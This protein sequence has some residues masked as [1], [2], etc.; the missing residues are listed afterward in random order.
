M[1]RRI[2]LVIGASG[3]V[4]RQVSTALAERGWEVVGTGNSRAGAGLLPLDLRD[5]TA[6]RETIARVRPTLCV[7]SAALTDVE[8][9]EAEPAL[10]EALNARAPAVTAAA[11]RAV[12]GRTIFLSTEY[13]FDGTAGPYAEDDPVCPISVYG[14][15]KLKGEQAVLAADPNSLAVRTTVV[16]SYAPEELNFAMQLINRLSNGQRMRI[17]GD[18][19]SSPTYAP[20]LAEAIARLCDSGFAVRG[21]LNIAGDEVLDRVAFARR[22]AAALNLDPGLI[23]AVRTKDL[24]QKAGRPLR[25]GL[26][27]DKLQALGV[28]PPT[29][30]AALAEVARLR[31][32]A[33]EGYASATTA[34]TTPALPTQF[35]GVGRL[36]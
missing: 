4:G 21:V 32:V 2:A 30:D 35:D 12:G 36:T 7:L 20:F 16:F 31:Q 6:I 8:R 1:N 11:C 33:A 15:T 18:Q 10:A 27:I 25:A 9:C 23:D 34:A 19:F 24:G 22:V 5:E 13:V 29:L 28:V 14:R 26:E 17:P 3:Q